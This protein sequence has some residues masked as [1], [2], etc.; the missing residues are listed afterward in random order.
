MSVSVNFYLP[1]GSWLH[2][3]DPRVKLLFVAT[4]LFLLILFQNLWLMLGAL[5]LLLALHWS[6]GTPPSKLGFILK[7]LLPVGLLMMILRTIFYPEGDPI[8]SFWVVEIT[9]IG[10]AQGTVLALRILTMALAVFAWLYTTSQADLVQSMVR[11]GLRHEWGLVLA[12]ALRYIP[13]FQGTFTLISEAQQ[14]RGLN[15]QQHTG[16]KRVRVMMP[17][18]V[19]MIISSLRDSGQLATALEARGYGK[20]HVTRTTLVQLH[21]RRWDYGMTGLLLLLLISFTY[22]RFRY[23]FGEQPLAL[24]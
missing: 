15:I 11:L 20:P 12:L 4:T 7:T 16:F 10:L 2:R 19:A 22:L 9:K 23:G 5:L 24:F 3:T 14:A 21:F 13:T 18:F 8:L 1:G 17:I 6:A